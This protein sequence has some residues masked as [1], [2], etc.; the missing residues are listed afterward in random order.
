MV[1]F[2]FCKTQSESRTNF[3]STMV[4]RTPLTRAPSP[5]PPRLPPPPASSS[6]RS[7]GPTSSWHAYA[8]PPH[9]EAAVS[10]VRAYRSG[11]RKEYARH[12]FHAGR[13]VGRSLIRAQEE[14]AARVRLTQVYSAGDGTLAEP[15]EEESKCQPNLTFDPWFLLLIENIFFLSRRSRSNS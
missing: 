6:L 8:V 13:H 5:A 2:F 4:K 9:R 1:S 7:T 14:T 10:V 3:T 12:A 11:I 15:G